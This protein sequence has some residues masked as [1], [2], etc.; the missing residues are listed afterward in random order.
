VSDVVERRAG[1]QVEIVGLKELRKQLRD[2]P[3][4]LRDELKG[5]NKAA[6]EIVRDE[7][8]RIVPQRTGALMRSITAQA[9]V[10]SGRVKA[11]SAK[12]VPYGAPVHFGWPSRP[13][14]GRRWRGGPIAPNP[15]LYEAQDRRVDEVRAAF[16]KAAAR[17][18]D[19]QNKE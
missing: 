3:K 12:K 9:S 17:W 6:A 5:A 13:N 18:V 2:A 1:A 16:E 8:R 4:E 11:G 19:Q 7:A 15:F 10:S 14:K